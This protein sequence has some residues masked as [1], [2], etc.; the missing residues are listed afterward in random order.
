MCR[1][2]SAGNGL[3]GHARGSEKKKGISRIRDTALGGC[4]N[5]L[6]WSWHPISPAVV[7][8][9]LHMSC[10]GKTIGVPL[11]PTAQK[12]SVPNTAGMQIP[13]RPCA[14][15]LIKRPERIRGSKTPAAAHGLLLC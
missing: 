4:I 13:N 10:M 8:A 12:L 7:V 3:A 2:T 15:A 5:P 14:R 9:W 11:L 1:W 6:E